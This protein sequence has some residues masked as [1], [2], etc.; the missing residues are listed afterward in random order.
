MQF[1]VVGPVLDAVLREDWL[2]AVRLRGDLESAEPEIMAL[3]PLG[4]GDDRP[5]EGTGTPQP[6]E[7]RLPRWFR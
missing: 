4:L 1:P 7:R 2:Y 5:F 6:P 3:P